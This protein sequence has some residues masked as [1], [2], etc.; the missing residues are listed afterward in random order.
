MNFVQHNNPYKL[1]TASVMDNL[2]T[3]QLN[4]EKRATWQYNGFMRFFNDGNG[5][6]ETWVDYEHNLNLVPVPVLSDNIDDLQVNEDAIV[7]FIATAEFKQRY[8]S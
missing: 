4:P 1:D 7:E 5:V 6:G 3:L 8:H 2:I